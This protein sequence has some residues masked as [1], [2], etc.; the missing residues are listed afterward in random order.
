M[1]TSRTLEFLPDFLKTTPNRKFLTATLDQLLSEPVVKKFNG[2][3]GRQFAPVYRNTD[4]YITEP[5]DQRQNYQ[6][7]PGVITVNANDQAE[8]Y[9][10]YPDL[11]NQ[12]SFYGGITNKHSRLFSN[13]TYTYDPRVDFDKLV[14]F[15]NYYWLQN[16]PDPVDVGIEYVVADKDFLMSED[17]IKNAYQINSETIVNPDLILRRGG[18]YRFIVNS[19][20]NNFWIQTEKGTSGTNTNI[21][22]LS[23]REIYGVANNGDDV[24]TVTFIVPNRDDQNTFKVMPLAFE[25]DLATTKKFNEIDNKLLANVSSIDGVTDIDDKFIIFINQTPNNADWQSSSAVDGNGNPVSGYSGQ[26]ISSANRSNVF[27][28]K[29]VDVPNG[30]LITLYSVHTTTVSTKIYVKAGITQSGKQYYKPITAGATLLQ[31]FPQI[32]AD[33]DTLYYQNQS[34]SALAGKIKLVD[35]NS[36]INVDEEIVGQKNY[37]SPNGIQFTTGLKV[38]FGAQVTPSKYQNNIYIVEGVGAAIKLIPFVS[39]VSTDIDHITINRASID[40]NDWSYTNKWFHESVIRS[41]AEYNNTTA[42]FDQ[43]KRATRPIIEFEAGLQLFN[44]G[45]EYLTDVTYY[46]DTETDA[47]GTE[48]LTKFAGRTNM[49]YQGSTLQTGQTIVFGKDTNVAIRK[50]VWEIIKVTLDSVPTIL[51]TPKYDVLDYHSIKVIGGTFVGKH[52]YLEGNI[53]AQGQSKL[54]KNQ[55]P[56]FDIVENDYSRFK[57]LPLSDFSGATIFGYQK[58][59]GTNDSILGF[60]L[61]YRNINNF[62]DIQFANTYETETFTYLE[63]QR[64]VTKNVASGFIVKNYSRT[65]R[66]K[67][68]VWRKT[69]KTSQQYQ[70]YTVFATGNISSFDFDLVPENTTENKTNIKVYINNQL[71]NLTQYTLTITDQTT[72]TFSK[73]LNQGDKLEVLIYSNDVDNVAFYQVPGNLEVNSLNDDFTSITLGQLRNHARQCFSSLT[74]LVGVELGSNNTRDLEYKTIPGTI[75]QHS[76]PV[77]YS[78]LFLSHDKANFVDSMF[79]AQREYI[80][81]KHRFLELAAGYNFYNNDQIVPIVD[82]ILSTI[83]SSKTVDSPWYYSDMVPNNGDRT[84]YNYTV[85]DIDIRNY[86]IESIFND[87]ELSNRAVLVYHN[88]KQLVKGIDYT[89]SQTIPAIT[90]T[91]NYIFELN[92][93]IQI[94]EYTNTD[95]NYIPETPTKLG[96]YPK[97]IPDIILDDR[98]SLPIQVIQG[99]DGSITPSFGDFRDLLLLELERRIFNNIKS[100]F[101]EDNLSVMWKVLPGKFRTSDY[102]KTEFDQIIS[103]TFLKWV[104]NSQLDYI[105]NTTYQSNDP[106]SWNYRRSTSVIDGDFLPGNWRSI[107]RYLYDTDRPH[108][109]PW[110]MLGFTIKPSWWE[111]Y[112]GPAPYTGGNTILWTD[113]RDGRIRQGDRAGIDTRFARADLLSLIPVNEYGELKTPDQFLVKSFDSNGISASWQ[114][115]D[116]GPV[117]TAWRLSSDYPFAMQIAMALAKPADYFSLLIDNRRYRYNVDLDQ[118]LFVNTKDRIKPS[119]IL[120]NGLTSTNSVDRVASWTNYVSDYLSSQGIQGSSYVKN[121]IDTLDVRLSYRMAGFADKKSMKIYAEQ[122]SPGSRN[123]SILIPSEN[124][125]VVLNKSAPSRRAVYSA[126]IVKRTSTGYSVEGYDYNSPYFTIVP[127][128]STGSFYTITGIEKTAKIYRD[129]Q[130]VYLTVPYGFEFRTRQQLVDFLVSYQRYLNGL[131]YQFDEFDEDLKTARDWILSAREF[132]TWSEQGWAENSVIVLSPVIGNLKLN[133]NE[134]TVDEINGKWTGSRLLDQNFLGINNSNFDAIRDADSF[135]IRTLN[136]K[137]IGL[138]D[139]SLVQYEHVLILDNE[140]VFGDIIYSPETGNR[141]YRLKINGVKSGNWTGRLSAPGFIFNNGQIDEWAMGRDYYKGDLV[142]YKNQIYSAIDFINA[143]TEFNFNNWALKENFNNESRLLLNFAGNAKKFLNIYDVDADYFDSNLEQY[144]NHLIGF[145]NRSYLDDFSLDSKTQT[146]FYQ[147]FIKEKGTKKSINALINVTFNKLVGDVDFAEEW[148][149]RVGSLGAVENRQIIEAILDEQ[150]NTSDPFG[151]EFLSTGAAAT[152]KFRSYYPEDLYSA[153]I[154]FNSR[155]FSNRNTQTGIFEQ[156]LTWAGPVADSE[157]DTVVFDLSTSTDQ[158]TNLVNSIGLGYSVWTAKDFSGRWNVYRTIA[159]N[160]Q[161][162]SIG[163]GLDNTCQI[164]TIENN[165]FQPGDVIV[166]KEFDPLLDG[167]YSILS[168]DSLNSFTANTTAIQSEYLAEAG[169]IESVG[170][171]YRLVSS[172]GNKLTDVTLQDWN[173]N[174]R[175]WLGGDADNWSVYQKT[176]PWQWKNEFRSSS[177]ESQWG[178][179]ISLT[180]DQSVLSISAPLNAIP[181]VEYFNISNIDTPY[182]KN[183]FAPV[184]GS[185]KFG[186]A[187]ANSDKRMFVSSMALVTDTVVTSNNGLSVN[188]TISSIV[189]PLVN[190]TIT[191]ETDIRTIT[192]VVN[193][194]SGSYTLTLNSAINIASTTVVGLTNN[195]GYIAVYDFVN[196]V[197]VPNQIIPAE[198]GNLDFGYNLTSSTDRKWL[199]VGCP[200]QN[201]VKAYKL[202][203]IATNGPDVITSVNGDLDYVLSWTPSDLHSVRVYNQTTDTFLIPGIDYTLSSNQIVLASNPGAGIIFRVTGGSY[204]KFAANISPSDAVYGDRFGESIK[205][206]TDGRQIVASAPYKST[207]SGAVYIFDRTVEAFLSTQGQDTFTTLRTLTDKLYEVSVNGIYKSVITDYTKQS[208]TSIKFNQTL[209]GGTRIEIE[210]NSWLLIKKITSTQAQNNSQ[211]GYSVDLCTNN[212]S[213][214]IGQPMYKTSTYV[215]GLVSRYQN[216]AR[217]FGS[218]LGSTIASPNNCVIVGDSIRINDQEIMFADVTL[219][220][221][222]AKINISS[223]PGVTASR[224]DN[225]LKL[226]SNSILAFDSLRILP[227]VT[228]DSTP[229]TEKLGLDI[230][231]FKQVLE[232]PDV[233]YEEFGKIVKV[234]PDARRVFVNSQNG[235]IDLF[236]S[237]DNSTTTFDLNSLRLNDRIFEAG[238]VHEFEVLRNADNTEELVFVQNLNPAS[239]TTGDNFGTNLVVGQSYAIVLSKKVDVNGKIDIFQS[240]PDVFGWNLV[241]SAGPVVDHNSVHT[242]ALYDKRKNSIITYLD[243]IDPLRGKVLG[244]AEGVID[245]KAAFDPAVYNVSSGLTATGQNYFWSENQVGRVWWN[246]DTVR[247]QEYQYGDSANRLKNWGKLMP[248]SQINV[249]E[250]VESSVLPSQY[251]AQGNSG[252]PKNIDD[253]E[254]SQ[255]VSVDP[256]TG[257]LRTRYYYWVTDKV[258]EIPGR[259]I[260]VTGIKNI[261]EQPQQQGIPYAAILNDH[262]VSLYN[263]RQFITGEDIVLKIESNLLGKDLPIHNEWHLLKEKNDETIPE[264]IIKKLIDSVVGDAIAGDRTVLVPDPNLPENQK[265]GIGIRP[266]QSMFVNRVQAAKVLIQNLNR[267]LAKQIL[268]GQRNFSRLLESD[269]VPDETEYEL[270]FETLEQ[271]LAVELEYVELPTGPEPWVDI[272]VRSDSTRNNNWSLYRL[273]IVDS[274]KTLT[275]MKTQAY[276]VSKYWNY[277]NWYDQDFDPRTIPDYVVNDF[278]QEPATGLQVGQL[279]KINNTGSGQWGIFQ[280]T[281]TGFDPKALE[282]A[283][284]EIDSLLYTPSESGIGFDSITY[285]D[286]FYDYN[287]S[288]D[289]RKL[290]NAIRQDIAIEDMT[291]IF[292]NAVFAMFKYIMHEQTQPDWIFKTS[293]I[294]VIHRIRKLVQYPSYIRDNQD[295][296]KSY[297]E[298]VKPYKTKIREYLLDYQGEDI[299]EFDVTDFDYPVFFDTDEQRYRHPVVGEDDDIIATPPWNYW[300]QGKS[301]KI[302]SV[303]VINQGTN[304]VSEPTLIVAGGDGTVRLRANVLAGKIVSVTVE[305]GGGGFLSSPNITIYSIPNPDLTYGSGAILKARITND[306]VR[307][308]DTTIK[309]DRIE[310]DSSIPAW[311]VGSMLSPVLYQPGD[312]FITNGKVYRVLTEY[313]QT[314]QA[315]NSFTTTT[316]SAEISSTEQAFL[317]GVEINSVAQF[318][319]KGYFKIE[320]E[321]FYY[322]GRDVLNNKLNLVQRAQFG[323]VPTNYSIGATVS[324]LD[325]K[326]A[327]PGDLDS[328]MKR[329]YYYYNPSAG[330]TA[331]D[332][333]EIYSGIDYPGVR[334]KA[335]KFSPTAY[336]GALTI[337]SVGTID[338]NLKVNNEPVDYSISK[339][340]TIKLI[341]SMGN[342]MIGTVLN[343]DRV[344]GDLKIELNESQGSGTFSSWT[345]EKE[346]VTVFDLENEGI[347]QPELE[348]IDLMYRSVFLDTSLGIKPEDINVDGGQYVDTANSHAPEELV[349]G[350]IYDTLEMRVFNKTTTNT[351]LGWR[352]FHSMNSN[353]T[354][355]N[356]NAQPTVQLVDAISN[357]ATSATVKFSEVYAMLEPM[358]K[359]N[360]DPYYPTIVIN[361]ETITYTGYNRIT[362]QIT[363]M[364][365]G[366][367]GTTAKSH[368]ANSFVTV[369]DNLK[370]TRFYYRISNNRSSTLAAPLAPSSTQIKLVN[371]ANFM[372]PYAP[373][374]RPGVVFINGEKIY[375]WTINYETNTLGQLVRGLHG[376]GIPNIHPTGSRVDDASDNQEITDSD[377]LSWAPF[378]QFTGSIS[379]TTLT[380]DPGVIGPI[381]VGQRIFGTGV[382][383]NTAIVAFISGAGANGTYQISVSHGSVAST[384]MRTGLS[385]EASNSTQVGFLKQELSY[386]V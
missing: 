318:P 211:F 317:F 64:Y 165:D 273:S 71:Q 158:L 365:R 327:D 88:G 110:E 180:D 370:D 91:D 290:L 168:K 360:G 378:T 36:I 160:Q 93:Q 135:E 12:I 314:G 25:S 352:V 200:E 106:K 272:L 33:L 310:Y 197:Y 359:P 21:P 355:S 326:L 134:S 246:L 147:G 245:Y 319:N 235:Y 383:P 375:Y 118:I 254:Y 13:Q 22:N 138:A 244:A 177:T 305:N 102:T 183:I 313:S 189:A 154:N 121:L 171:I 149:I 374:D 31:V 157:V 380:V 196:Q 368:P 144:S 90:F 306:R 24:G 172:R 137:I 178:R 35:N 251:Q 298:E 342:Y 30:K 217:V 9:S 136:D 188:L 50:V 268:V 271:L 151:V 261:I 207:N 202:V 369:L 86:Q 97:F 101:Q 241:K 223:I 87:S 98:Y 229:T 74:D 337:N 162:Q 329:A 364:T 321:I 237:F 280:K 227:G 18:T 285:D 250:W 308:F 269:P 315:L 302:E 249:Y 377:P 356:H 201:K 164:T 80:K 112:Y 84:N 61:S 270:E 132:L 92:D 105:S 20:G 83:T 56:L 38:R 242:L 353:T 6:L 143:S 127:S 212:C 297:I 79:Y 62:G 338:I 340:Q 119:Q 264:F 357:V 192:N 115:G 81:F 257:L 339:G 293:F 334:V 198:A 69:E 133:D 324:R 139:L 111:V 75:L 252:T 259:N 345:I 295:Y 185:T 220:H 347:Q 53:W 307:T 372:E 286:G 77:I 332:L 330:M 17:T 108:T 333:K 367:N 152:E 51:L 129:Y 11:L 140:T 214:Y 82:E 205:T 96:L 117:E 94:V 194:G 65:E 258:T 67:L 159:T 179:A 303:T 72:I 45:R 73:N 224:V 274:Q 300:N 348:N 130:L 41:T 176:E 222:V 226:E 230:F 267:E 248:G 32:T 379:G 2:Y 385:F 54:S 120:I 292:T 44:F 346:E 68:N 253:S 288:L 376:T 141:Q 26:S 174:D 107:Y 4:S 114:V 206:S 191:R 76:S 103:K 281:E 219:D 3:I 283:T 215:G 225:K 351:V 343:Y 46:D 173:L 276:N 1:A 14:N 323:T 23:T 234:S 126:V 40:G 145:K 59:T 163:Y 85:L 213:L 349:P 344:S 210:S 331:N 58:G 263:C 161:A 203:E 316:L 104:G 128:R 156:D 89:F 312:F 218:I 208:A 95:G 100:E 116:S 328:A 37:I 181:K 148:A 182:L 243:Y 109:H 256:Q 209:V 265:Y 190:W 142:S 204:Y 47:F 358:L 34:N 278:S 166:I 366:V 27:K 43:T 322:G 184:T 309:F 362:G 113:L 216:Y 296:Y 299:G 289:L 199:Y 382:L 8:F 350:R 57:N 170:P 39:N 66:Q 28:I 335:E 232:P 301:F 195:K 279:I 361:G 294:S 284:I 384:T 282:K 247:F 131:G 55:S 325:Y 16:G 7:E 124:Y 386:S 255:V 262:S 10:S 175:F 146:K 29:L 275:L 238:T 341:G 169:T 277:I 231:Q 78:S 373:D 336:S 186:Y 122:T 52:Y 99:H 125:Q 228:G 60:P 19:T 371:A 187:I 287:P 155:L 123:D 150:S 221:V 236:T 48:V 42:L 167:V 153:P 363:G 5:S 49:S 354:D 233:V 266:R 239:A 193:N 70:Q 15:G 311:Q 240:N 304:Y 260:S 63:D 320:N 381:A 291:Y